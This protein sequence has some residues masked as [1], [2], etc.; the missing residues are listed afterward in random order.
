VTSLPR[1]TLASPKS[2]EVLAAPRMAGGYTVLPRKGRSVRSAPS[3]TRPSA[4][5]SRGRRRAPARR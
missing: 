4:A 3:S 2:I 1:L 5:A